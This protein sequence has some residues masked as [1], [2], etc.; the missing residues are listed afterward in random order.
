M[1]R[2][3][4]RVFVSSRMEELGPERRAIKTALDD[5][6][7]DAWVF[8]SDAGARPQSTRK[9]YVDELSDDD[10]YIGIFWKG[11]GEY[12]IEEYELAKSLKKDRLICLKRTADDGERDPRLRAFL[13][14]LSDIEKGL[15]IRWF[16]GPEDLAA[17]IKDD[18]AG[19]QSDIVLDRRQPKGDQP[20][21]TPPRPD[22]Y[23]ERQAV[24]KLKEALLDAEPAVTRA[25]LHGMGGLGKT[26]TATAFAGDEA[27]LGRFPDGVLWVTLGQHPDLRQRLADWGGALND[28]QVLTAPY[29]DIQTG[30]SRLRSRL[31]DKAC[32]LVLD[33]VWET[34]HVTPFLVGGPKCLLLLTTRKADVADAIGGKICRLDFM[35]EDEALALL[36]NWIGEIRPEDVTMARQIAAEMGGVPQAIELAAAQIKR[37][38]SW[39]GF[40]QR[41][42]T[43]KL[44]ALKRGRRETKE[45]NLALSL[46]LSFDQLSAEDR[47]RF[48]TLAVIPEDAR[49]S[50]RTAAALWNSDDVEAEDLLVDLADQALMSRMDGSF[51]IHDLMRDLLRQHL[52]EAGLRQA[53]GA[54]AEGLQRRYPGIEAAGNDYARHF[55]GYHLQNAGKHQELYAL[56]AQQPAWAEACY[57]AERT[58]ARFADDLE[59]AWAW[60]RRDGWDVARQVRC[61]TIEASTRSLAGRISPEL[62]ERAVAEGRLGVGAALQEVARMP[63]SFERSRALQKLVGQIPTSLIP[64]ALA[65]AR[66]IQEVRFRVEALLPLSIRL[67]M[68][69]RAEVCTDMLAALPMVEIAWLPHLMQ[70]IA[71]VLPEDLR[72]ASVAAASRVSEPD[73]ALMV[74]ASTLPG[75]LDREILAAALAMEDESQRA[76]VLA[77]IALVLDRAHLEEILAAVRRLTANEARAKA[78]THIV[79]GLG[80]AAP[81]ALAEEALQVSRALEPEGARAWAGTMLLPALPAALRPKVLRVVEAFVGAI[82]EPKARTSA[83]TLLATQ[84]EGGD[85]ARIAAAALTSANRLPNEAERVAALAKIA[86][87]LAGADRPRL[88]PA[89]RDL[90]IRAQ[91]IKL[92]SVALPLQ[93]VADRDALVQELLAE[94]ANAES[95]FERIIAWEQA[96]P[97]FSDELLVQAVVFVLQNEDAGERNWELAEIFKHLPQVRQLTL[98]EHCGVLEDYRKHLANPGPDMKLLSWIALGQP[99]IWPEIPVETELARAR[100][101]DDLPERG[102]LL[103][104]LSDYVAPARRKGV[105]DEGLAVARLI[106]HD[107]H[108][109]KQAWIRS[110]VLVAL[111]QRASGA[112]LEPVLQ[113]VSTLADPGARASA[114]ARLTD[115]IAPEAR[116]RLVQGVLDATEH[117]G[118]DYLKSSILKEVSAHLSRATADQALALARSIENAEKRA[119]LLAKMLQH[120]PVEDRANVVREAQQDARSADFAS[121]RYYI[122]ATLLKSAPPECRDELVLDAQS[123]VRDVDLP[124]QHL[125]ALIELIQYRPEP[126]RGDSYREALQVASR[127]YPPMAI[128]GLLGSAEHLPPQT[129]EALASDGVRF[130]REMPPGRKRGE[131]LA[132]VADRLPVDERPRVLNE[133]LDSALSLETISGL[134]RRDLLARIFDV[135]KA[136]G[137]AG[138]EDGRK[139]LSR[140]LRTLAA[141]PRG[142]FLNDLAT[143]LPVI[144]EIGGPDA[145]VGTYESVRDVCRWWP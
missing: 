140:I 89:A 51:V 5:I 37:L 24:G 111:G 54:M 128:R 82:E 56:V 100:I 9:T 41:W 35:S 92:L 86:P 124:D 74:L 28:P 78:L 102:E 43:R 71:G 44:D 73:Q 93:P 50:I 16:H 66:D 87:L 81:P 96:V 45:D 59:R 52:G 123:A 64:K 53:H 46:E 79:I 14:Q 131:L 142:E 138:L 25:A 26:V 18:V 94:L 13:D 32:L 76:R 69:L 49:I 2:R 98:L 95:G 114:R 103:A 62:L 104:R 130:A 68:T 141:N 40:L 88:V 120:L 27:V 122:L 136:I 77:A 106:D 12:T 48:D 70:A 1:P 75:V 4:L 108:G 107:V 132:L 85:L 135:W 3:R 11:Y 90:R 47:P 116:D 137:F 72:P 129:V 127:M 99:N 65:I 125:Q 91:R 15:T 57:E 119:S 22:Q 80:K 6:R 101:I 60:T 23:V 121:N 113:E 133:A 21:Q 67:P 134:E 117:L 33:D 58:Y 143:V 63:K 20:L 61:A 17:S 31:N 19:W 7:I 139:R 112:D 34:H 109:S 145:I 38:G 84:T 118:S 55:L 39:A 36:R 105:L 83:L 97:C 144:S 115:R 10:L 30:S 126:Q 8:E 42:E 29:P 110:H